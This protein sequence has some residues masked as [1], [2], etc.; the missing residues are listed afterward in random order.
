VVLVTDAA[1]PRMAEMWR[2]LDEVQPRVFTMRVGEADSTGLFEDLMQSWARVND[3]HYD[4]L[5]TQGEMDRAFD[6]AATLLRRPAAYT[7]EVGSTVEKPPSPGQLQV[8]SQGLA[9]GAVALILDASGSMLKR[10]EG[11]RRIE[12]AKELLSKAAGEHIPAGT[13]VAL[14]V[15]GHKEANS[16]R[17]DLVVP[18][19]PLDPEVM[20]A[21]LAGINARNLAKTPI[22]ASLARVEADLKGAKGTRV[23]VLVTDGEETCDGDPEAEVRKLMERGLDLRLEIVGFAISD[24]DLKQQFEGWAEEGGG[25]YF[26]AGDTASLESSLAEAMRTPFTVF[27]GNGEIVAEGTVDGAAVELPPGRYRVVVRTSPVATFDEV[28]VSEK[29]LRRLELE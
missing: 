18:M 6:R 25:R 28:E 15:F 7:L 8:T 26:D 9:G 27:D 1:T 11:R 19:A 21:T 29:Q 13:P 16:C 22:A 17:T 14:R 4:Y 20:K 23:V 2:S 3:G 12:I 10:L 5:S 24:A